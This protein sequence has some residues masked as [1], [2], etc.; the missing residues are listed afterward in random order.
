VNVF[1]DAALDYLGMGYHP[2][3]VEPR[4]KR[5]LTSWAYYQDVAPTPEQIHEWWTRWPDANI[6][7]VLG[8]GTFAVD[9]DTAEAWD[10]VK[11]HIPPDAP[12]SKTA[13]GYHA[14][15]AGTVPDRVGAAPGVDIRGVGYIVASPS[16]HPT[17]HVY[18]WE[19]P[20]CPADELPAA[21][22]ALLALAQRKTAPAQPAVDGD[23]VTAALAGVAEGGR[24]AMCTRLAGYLIGRGL[25]QDAVEAI[26]VGWGERCSPAFP[27][28]DVAKCVE[29]IARR[30]GPVD[31]APAP[32]VGIAE[33]VL[34]VL[35][36]D[37]SRTA[38]RSTGLAK[39]DDLLDGGVRPGELIL[40]GARP[41]VGKTAW[42]LQLSRVMAHAGHGVLVVTREM[43]R[44]ALTRRLLCQ[45]SLVRFSA[46]KTGVLD[47]TEQR[48]LTAGV[49][50]LSKLP[51]WISTLRTVDQLAETLAQFDAGQIGFVVVDYLQRMYGPP[52]LEKRARVEY[53]ADALKDLAVQHNVPVLCLSSLSRPPKQERDW[54]PGL[55]DLRESGELEHG[56]DSVLLMHREPG[57]ELTELN[58]GKQRDGRVGVVQLT[59]RGE[60]L[61]FEEVRA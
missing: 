26:L 24:D 17:G 21:S 11:Q 45:E 50:R 32:A 41:G 48:M 34:E 10:A 53:V 29:S 16:V 14:L 4:G 52:N 28:A 1:R 42:M 19:T 25:P 35:S 8:R 47:D 20:L 3:P 37:T 57:A 6:A 13:K 2:I 60:Y 22:P 38:A 23:W 30:H 12:L 33:A 55:G 44:A 9:C 40:L 36:A 61:T 46:L 58:L 51:L 18:H 56:G 49:G 15:L 59:F 27:P 39:L 54:R 43:T 7:L 31:S 5:P